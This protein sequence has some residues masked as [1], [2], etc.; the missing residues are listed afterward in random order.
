MGKAYA[1]VDGNAIG[2]L[3]YPRHRPRPAATSTLTASV[4]D[5]LSSSGNPNHGG[6]NFEVFALN[7]G[8]GSLVTGYPLIYTQSLLD[9]INQ[10]YLASP[11]FSIASATVSA[12]VVTITT[13]A[14]RW[15]LRRPNRG[16]LRRWQQV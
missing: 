3:G 13:N 7:L 2:V 1:G 12:G 6:S 15:I 16:D 9:A 10:N 8:D 14:A 5:Y 11:T 4:V